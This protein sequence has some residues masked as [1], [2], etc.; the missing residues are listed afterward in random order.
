MKNIAKYFYILLLGA[1]LIGLSFFA[2][3]MLAHEP[4][5]SP[6]GAPLPQFLIHNTH[7]EET[8]AVSIFDAE[9]GNYYVFLPSYADLT[10]LTLSL[11]KENLFSLGTMDLSEGMDCSDFQLETPYAF[12]VNRQEVATLWFYQ[13]A[14]V[15]TLYSNTVT[16]SMARIHD[17]KNYEEYA[18]L[19]L[20]TPE[21]SLNFTDR[22]ITLSGRGN[23]TWGLDKRPYSLQLSADGNL[24][25]MG[26]AK[27]WVLLANANDETNLNN[28]LVLDLAARVGLQWSP[29]NQWVDLYLNGEYN[30]LYLLT[31][32]VE[33]HESRLELD[34]NSGD[35]LCKID[36]DH[37]AYELQHPFLTDAGR[38]VEINAPQALSKLGKSNINRLVN[39]MEQTILSGT[40][41]QEASIIDLDSWARKYL[42]DEI[43]GNIDADITST[44]FYC[45]D[46]VFYAGPVWDYDMAFG[47]SIRNQEADSFIAKNAKKS[48]IFLSPYYGALYTNESFYQRMVEIYRTEFLP[49][50]QEMIDGGISQQAA[51]IH[52]AAQS[53]SIRWRSMFDKH[54]IWSAEMVHTT[55]GLMDYFSRRVSFLNS[56]WLDK[57]EYCTVQ[58]ERGAG[59]VYRNFSVR[60]GSLLE[61]TRVDLVDTVW[62][63]VETGAAVDFSQ[64][65]TKDRIVSREKP[66]ISNSGW[67]SDTRDYIAFLSII[68]LIAVFTGF[69]IIDIVR[70]SSERKTA[71]KQ[72]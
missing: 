49:V 4:I 61:I 58:F 42:I 26:Q 37:R 44:Y 33:V 8:E 64:P 30:G 17:D 35:F 3:K 57:V 1:I 54:Q 10:Q 31:E 14:N 11:P 23:T 52:K 67:L 60:N 56:A 5:D 70:R 32:K 9:D 43:S 15:A 29:E 24:L 38:T 68:A 20:Y 6:T 45:Q 25:G 62:Y 21:G 19:M 13:S 7:T 39:Q 47:N 34:T 55:D 53:N 12:S 48:S 63:D 2:V 59:A 36:L 69:V 22:R 72:R 50:L 27:N 66:S 46:G 40:D 16:G 28:K 41:L 71:S 65:I 51:F 18:S